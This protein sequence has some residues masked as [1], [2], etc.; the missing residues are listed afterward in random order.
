MAG[1]LAA[2]RV[3]VL[4]A[5]PSL[6]KRPGVDAGRRVSLVVD[7]VA[8]PIRPAA[9]EVVEPDLV[10]GC[11]RRV[12]REMPPDSGVAVVGAGDHRHRV[13]SHDAADALLHLLVA[14]ER[15]LLLRRDRVDVRGLDHL[16][17]EVLHAGPLEH[18]A[19]QEPGA[20]GPLGLEHVVQRLDP[21][22]SLLRVNVVKLLFE[23]GVAHRDI[24]RFPPRTGMP[25]ANGPTRGAAIRTRMAAL[26]GSA[27]I[28][29]RLPLAFR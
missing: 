7:L 4:L 8:A 12:R 23:S 10:K 24:P 6:E 17:P 29:P 15:R 1:G 16:D 28:A 19:Q 9:E 18:L 26:D 25:A 27:R 22:R 3:E 20:L 11:S 13:P 2:E 21:L 14:G 5:E